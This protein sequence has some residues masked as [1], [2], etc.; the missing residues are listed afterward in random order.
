VK[1][2]D[3]DSN[4]NETKDTPSFPYRML[5]TFLFTHKQ[6]FRVDMTKPPLRY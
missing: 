2:G 5:C 6:R 4:S 3:F 1:S